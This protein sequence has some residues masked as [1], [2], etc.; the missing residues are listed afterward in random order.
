MISESI[1]GV[2]SIIGGGSRLTRTI[3]MGADYY[4]FE[5]AKKHHPFG[6]GK[7]CRIRNAIIDKDVSIGDDVQLEN[8]KNLQNAEQDGI[9]IKDGIIVVP[10]GMRV[11]S[12]YVL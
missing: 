8:V 2:R 12:G 4:D 5:D 1:I 3:L 11:P 6:I 10:K 7:N 9:S